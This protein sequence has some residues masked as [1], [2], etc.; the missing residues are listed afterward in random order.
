MGGQT[1]DGPAGGRAFNKNNNNYN[2]NSDNNIHININQARLLPSQGGAVSIKMSA[3]AEA[4]RKQYMTVK[5]LQ[6][7]LD[8]CDLQ[9]HQVDEVWPNIYIGNVYV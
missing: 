4:K 3:A 8:S 2:N 9:L 5:D 6:K 7:V 1:V